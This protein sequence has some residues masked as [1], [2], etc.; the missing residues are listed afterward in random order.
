MSAPIGQAVFNADDLRPRFN[1][2]HLVI[3]LE[4]IVREAHCYSRQSR[5][6]RQAQRRNLR[7]DVDLLRQNFFSLRDQMKL[8]FR[9]FSG[10]IAEGQGDRPLACVGGESS[11]RSDD[12][13]VTQR[14]SDGHP[15]N[16][17]HLQIPAVRR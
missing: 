2:C 3:A 1:E 17:F 13:D 8:P 5:R 15:L 6:Q 12:P 4:G 10:R 11:L 9:T 16:P 7:R 14:L